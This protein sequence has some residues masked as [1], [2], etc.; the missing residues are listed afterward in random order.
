M[1][2]SIATQGVSLNVT[3]IIELDWHG[4]KREAGQ[5]EYRLGHGEGKGVMHIIMTRAEFRSDSGKRRLS[6]IYAL[7][8][9]VEI[10]GA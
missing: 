5:R 4:G 1:V 6:A 8:E 2:S 10:K 9:H 7:S 3:K